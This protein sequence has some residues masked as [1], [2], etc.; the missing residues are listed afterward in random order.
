[1]TPRIVESL[2]GFRQLEPQWTSIVDAGGVHTPY[3]SFAWIDNWLCHRAR[4][5]EPYILVFQ[6]GGT[7]APFGKYRV[8]GLRVLR[9]LGT[10][11]SDYLGLIS[12]LPVAEAWDAL[13]QELATRRD[14]WDLLHLHSV[15]DRE[16]I[17]TALDRHIGPGGRHRPYDTCPWVPTDRPWE[18]LLAS[19]KKLR[20]EV[21]R[22]TRRLEAQGSLV[23]DVV[24]PPV[25][26][27]LISELE[28][29]ER[30]SWKW[31]SG[32]AALRP[33]P[34]RDFLEAVLRDPR[35]SFQLW[36]L[37]ISAQL[38]AFALVLVA[39]NRWYYYLPT[40]RQAY[41]NAGSY[42]LA[43]IIEQACKSNCVLVDLLR[44]PHTYKLEWADSIDT[45][46]E[47]VSPSNMRGSAAALAY[48]AKWRVA[49]NGLLHRLRNRI[50][51]IGDR[52]QSSPSP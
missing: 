37:R 12:T 19:R 52:R 29:V 28:E 25:P 39:D 34:Q 32:D 2:E 36:L 14:A 44:G 46:Y 22:W 40:F 45:V 27:L 23:L 16:V 38:I 48:V 17:V 26:D 49:Q 3:E 33:G 50:C 11:D 4:G 1:L 35:M 18:D 21:R 6:D 51:D 7:I 43:R 13:A 10:G 42:L 9:L 20:Y 30:A 15:R 5:I 41:Q 24:C 31:K 8:A 47:I